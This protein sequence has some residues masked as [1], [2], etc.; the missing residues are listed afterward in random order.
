MRHILYLSISTLL[1]LTSCTMKKENK[2]VEPFNSAFKTTVQTTKAVLVNLSEELTLTG[3]VEYNPDQVMSYTP[4]VNGIVNRMYFSLGDK[5]TKGQDLVDIRSSEVGAL[6]ADLAEAKDEL[7][8]VE[9][10][11]EAAQMMFEDHML[12]QKDLLETEAKVR[13]AKSTYQ[14]ITNDLN[15]LGKTKANGLF[16]VSA[17][18]TGYIVNKNGASG[19]TLTPE[20]EPL[21]TIA[22]LK[23]VWVVASVY[24]SNLTSVKEGMEVS[25][26]LLPYPNEVFTGKISH[27]SQVFDSEEKILKARIEMANPDLKFKPEMAAVVKLK[28]ITNQPYLSV[29]SEALIFDSNRY[30]VVVESQSQDYRIK[31][32][33]LQGHNETSTYISSGLTEGDE[34]VVKN[35]LLIYSELKDGQD[36]A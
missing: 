33:T 24:A 31:E 7:A 36:N 12:S 14:R 4:L 19:S 26:S 6:Q 20:G 34:V 21:F 3:K 13:Q 9:R 27:I 16:T 10:E 5:V 28:E 2:A 1:L 25:I 23:K 15:I 35:H 8:I 32:V 17:P 30:F 29:P 22:D 18:M 11:L